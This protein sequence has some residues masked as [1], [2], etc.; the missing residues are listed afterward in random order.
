MGLMFFGAFFIID[1]L[2]T[3]F[4]GKKRYLCMFL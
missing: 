1:H 4:E 2:V 3:C